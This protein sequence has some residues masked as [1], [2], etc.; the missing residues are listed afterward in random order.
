[1]QFGDTDQTPL[2]NGFLLL[3][4][5]RQRRFIAEALGDIKNDRHQDDVTIDIDGRGM[6]ID[7]SHL[8]AA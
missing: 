8:T 5:L 4:Q 7:R 3:H 1:M 2:K 6:H